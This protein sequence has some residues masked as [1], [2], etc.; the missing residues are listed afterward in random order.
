MKH[1]EGGYA[2]SLRIRRKKL[3]LVM[4]IRN[5]SEKGFHPLSVPFERL[6]VG[7]GIGL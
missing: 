6:D 3:Q 4:S 5:R 2:V 1:C 7:E